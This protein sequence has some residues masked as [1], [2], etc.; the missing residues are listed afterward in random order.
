MLHVYSYGWKDQILD[1][2]FGDIKT[3]CRL[4]KERTNEVKRVVV[5]DE[6]GEIVLSLYPCW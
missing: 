1:A 4:W 6:A 3:A 5:W 2:R